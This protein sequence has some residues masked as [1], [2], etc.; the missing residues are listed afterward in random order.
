M[1]KGAGE[2][3]C[4]PACL[5]GTEKSKQQQHPQHLPQAQAEFAP[6]QVGAQRKLCVSTSLMHSCS[7]PGFCT[8]CSWTGCTLAPQK[9]GK[10]AA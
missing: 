1:G 7:D 5:S 6:L 2:D 4:S 3:G 10:G 8:M 9:Q